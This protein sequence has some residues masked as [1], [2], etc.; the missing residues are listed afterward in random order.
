MADPWTTWVAAA[1]VLLYEETAL[2]IP[3]FPV[4][5]STNNGQYPDPCW[6]F[7]GAEAAYMHCSTPS[8]IRDLSTHTFWHD[9]KG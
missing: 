2:H 4:V 9:T 1:G 5:D 7:L 8:Y 6:G 3:G